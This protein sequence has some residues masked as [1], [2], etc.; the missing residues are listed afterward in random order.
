MLNALKHL[1]LSCA[2]AP[3]LA[4]AFSDLVPPLNA[5]QAAIESARCFYCY[6]APCTRACP[7]DIDVASFIRSIAQNNINGA[8]QTILSSNILGGSC[9]RVCPTEVLCEQACVRNH[10]AEADPV[11]IGSLQRYAVDNMHFET[12]PFTRA[13]AS[14]LTVAVVGAGPAG[15]ACAHRLAM[16]G[17]EVVIFEARNKPGGLNEY[18]IAKYKLTQNYAQKE[19]EFVLQIGGIRIEY[20][21]RLGENLPLASL[22]EK[23]AAVFVAIGLDDSRKLGLEHEDAP[24]MMAAVDYIAELRQAEDLRQLPVASRAIVLGAGNTAVDMAVQMARLGA[25]EVT[26][27]YRRDQAAM[28]ATEHEQE[29]AKA[30][31]VRI[32]TWAQPNQILL[33]AEGRVRGMRFE[34]TELVADKLRGTGN[35]FELPADAIF[36]AI[37]QSLLTDDIAE[38]GIAVVRDKFAVDAN[39]RTSVPGV[40]AG[41][42]CIGPGEDLTVQA[43]QHGKLAAHAI[44]NDLAQASQEQAHG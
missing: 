17:H 41:G 22:R 2:D 4:Q 18:G 15:L 25:D 28:S 37:G 29:I 8:A 32:K 12:H 5:R 42:D 27:V 44:H 43:V 34:K 36:K 14:G 3:T 9:A 16:L 26:M 40:Y 10:Q 19:V 33:D 7:S 1:G 31:G 23:Y 38:A 24:G 11:R 35:Y 30:A 13:P 6:D 39:Y 20:G 21:M